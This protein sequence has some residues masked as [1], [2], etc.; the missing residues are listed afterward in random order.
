MTE[1]NKLIPATEARAKVLQITEGFLQRRLIPFER[2]LADNEVPTGMMYRYL[3]Y[4]SSSMAAWVRVFVCLC[5][6]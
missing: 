6:R 5:C 2:K 4:A 1:E 3:S